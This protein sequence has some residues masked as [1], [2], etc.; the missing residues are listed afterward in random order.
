MNFR[1]RL[2][3]SLASIFG[4]FF[5]A[6]NT[7]RYDFRILNRL[8][9]SSAHSTVLKRLHDLGTSAKEAITEMGQN[10]STKPFLVV[11]DNI[12]KYRPAW[13]QVVGKEAELKSGIAATAIMME[14]IL[15]GAFDLRSIEGKK[16]EQCC[17]NLAVG[18]LLTDIDHKHLEGVAVGLLLRT[19]VNYV[20]G[21]S[22][23]KPLIKE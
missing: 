12:N 10:V 7:T 6:C 3:N 14:D 15:T 2:V 22:H 17:S 1:N 23:L 4:V 5:F 9:I 20:P 8:G 18:T 11:Y 21:L 13:R 19:T 16:A